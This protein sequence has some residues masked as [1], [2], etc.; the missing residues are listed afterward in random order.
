MIKANGN[1]LLRTLP[2]PALVALAACQTPFDPAASDMRTKSGAAP[3]LQPITMEEIRGKLPPE[4]GC[5]FAPT[6]GAPALLIGS[7]FVRGE[8]PS[9]AAVKLNGR[10]EVLT[11]DAP[12]YE[13]LTAGPKFSNG[14]GLSVAVERGVEPLGGGFENQS[15]QANLVLDVSDGRKRTYLDGVW[16]CGP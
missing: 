9:K 2:L 1:C 15:W 10:V 6:S 8:E 16:T 13:G 5:S 7:G 11:A 4:L 14:S 3:T 12:G